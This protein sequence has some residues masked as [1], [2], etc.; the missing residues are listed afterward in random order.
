VKRNAGMVPPLGSRPR[1]PGCS[2]GA[3]CPRQ[4]LR[5]GIPG[6]Y[7]GKVEA[8][9]R[10]P[11]GKVV[12]M[13]VKVAGS[14]DHQGVNGF[15]SGIRCGRSEPWSPEPRKRAGTNNKR[16]A[17]ARVR[18]LKHSDVRPASA[19]RAGKRAS[20]SRAYPTVAPADGRG[21]LAGYGLLQPPA[22]AATPTISCRLRSEKSH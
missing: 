2:G 6:R 7:S 11:A 8:S 4:F 17:S 10:L 14:T 20:S 12:C 16:R 1:S 22:V 3:Y 18:C 21:H 9:K 15:D 19:L 5:E 13:P